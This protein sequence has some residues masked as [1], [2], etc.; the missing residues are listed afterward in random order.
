MSVASEV[1]YRTV[2]HPTRRSGSPQDRGLVRDPPGAAL[3]AP[4]FWQVLL[5]ARGFDETAAE[6]G[7]G[8]GDT[9]GVLQRR[10]GA[11][12][13]LRL[14]PGV[15]TPPTEDTTS[16]LADAAPDVD[17]PTVHA[18]SGQVVATGSEPGDRIEAAAVDFL[19]LL[20]D[21][22]P[23]AG[24]LAQAVVEVLAGDRP[25][26]Q[27]RNR[28]AEAIYTELSTLAPDPATAPT[29]GRTRVARRPQDRPRICSVHVSRPAAGVAEVAAR[30]ET[31]GRSRAVALRLQEWRGR[32]Q[33][34]ALV[35]G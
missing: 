18:E 24:Q 13:P 6:V 7:P 3:T 32:W 19:D 35:V 9:G 8:P 2:P 34:S 29:I 16:D 31:D 28:V 11:G 17:P 25:L 15:R 21:P 27:L 33:C 14:V 10:H 5:P 12:R 30:V 20:P 22:R 26:T 23:F 4:G 1:A